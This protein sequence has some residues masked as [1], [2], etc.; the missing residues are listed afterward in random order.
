MKA[1]RYLHP[2]WRLSDIQAVAVSN[3]P[4]SSKEVEIMTWSIRTVVVFGLC[5]VVALFVASPIQ[6]QDKVKLTGTEVK[7]LL[8]KPGAITFGINHKTNGVYTTEALKNG[9]RNL[10][11]QRLG[12][13]LVRGTDIGTTKIV[14]D[15]ACSKWSFGPETCFDVYRLGEDKYESRVGDRLLAT[16]YRGQT[17]FEASKDKVKL[18]GAELKEEESQYAIWAGINHSFQSVWI[19]IRPSSG[20]RELYWRSL[21]NPGL[22]MSYG[23]TTR[24]V[25]DQQCTK[26]TFGPERCY[27][28]Y[29]TGEGKGETWFQGSLDSSFYNLK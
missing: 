9:K 22:S 27:D 1:S 11:W 8:L 21:S 25:G 28:I 3:K 2:L 20:K 15:Q 5:V 13:S 17:A 10:Y 26:W 29:R 24:I 7:E 16:W 19:M 14:G 12:N 23:G 18:T 4:L 6:G